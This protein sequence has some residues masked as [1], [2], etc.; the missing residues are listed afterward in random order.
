M[1]I[2]PHFTRF[3]NDAREFD[4]IL[5]AELTDINERK[6]FVYAFRLGAKLAIEVMTDKLE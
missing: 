2:I 5:F 6:I 4:K 1:N 3:V